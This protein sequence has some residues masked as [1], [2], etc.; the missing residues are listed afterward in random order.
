MVEN[1]NSNQVNLGR[2]YLLKNYGIPLM[3]ELD[4]HP[5]IIEFTEIVLNV[6]EKLEKKILDISSNSEEYNPR[7]YIMSRNELNTLLSI[8]KYNSRNEYQAN[9]TD[10]TA[11]IE[12]ALEKSKDGKLD[13][14]RLFENIVSQSNKY[15]GDHFDI[16]TNEVDGKYIE[17]FIPKWLEQLDSRYTFGKM[18]KVFLSHAYTDQLLTISLFIYLYNNGI[19]LYVDWMHNGKLKTIKLKNKL[20]NEL[21]SSN[22]ILFL[23]TLNSELKLRGGNNQIRQW[24]AWEIGCF[25]YIN[26]FKNNK[27]YINHYINNTTPQSDMIDGYNVMT[28]IIPNVGIS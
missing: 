26:Q 18:P 25:D 13:V 14:R 24:C 15:L 6:I 2:T 7:A 5:S 23:R 3:K 9:Y 16:F 17:E 19:Y 12:K 21:E 22:Q 20:I 27:F 4:F 11:I 10:I 8:E 1:K 28:G